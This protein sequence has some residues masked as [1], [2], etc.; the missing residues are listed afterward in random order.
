MH[1]QRYVPPYNFA[2]VYNGLKN[3]DDAFAWLDRAYEARDVMLAAFIKSESVWD[4]LR[5]E[6]R[7]KNL[8]RRMNLE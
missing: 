7:F 3:D 2:L 8:I 1:H 6:G 4:R 5:A